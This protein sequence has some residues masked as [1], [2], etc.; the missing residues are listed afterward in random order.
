MI[1]VDYESM[2]VSGDML[3]RFSSKEALYQAVLRFLKLQSLKKGDRPFIFKDRTN[4]AE[5]RRGKF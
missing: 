2:T 1:I 5:A 3:Q 4:E